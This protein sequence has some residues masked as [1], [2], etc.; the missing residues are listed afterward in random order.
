MVLYHI[1]H[2]PKIAQITAIASSACKEGEEG[3]GERSW[4]MGSSRYLISG[5]LDWRKDR[6]RTLEIH[7]K[8]R[9]C[10]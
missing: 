3:C 5:D 9:K 7:M 10:K 2:T 1:P 4:E 6:V 8:R